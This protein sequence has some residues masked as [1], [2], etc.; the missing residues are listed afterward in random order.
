MSGW[1]YVSP[2]KEKKY[3]HFLIFISHIILAISYPR[4]DD[5]KKF[6]KAI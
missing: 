1:K 5:I 2:D 3:S 4:C 6:R